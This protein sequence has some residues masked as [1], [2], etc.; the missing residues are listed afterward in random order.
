[1]SWD[2]ESNNE[3]RPQ[4]TNYSIFRPT[5]HNEAFACILMKLELINSHLRAHRFKTYV[6][7][8]PYHP[9]PAINF[10]FTRVKFELN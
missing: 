6:V 10:A 1:M 3:N 5:E 2:D 8:S 7:I 9:D 4:P